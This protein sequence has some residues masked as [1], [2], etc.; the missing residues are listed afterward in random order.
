MSLCLL[1]ASVSLKD[2]EKGKGSWEWLA[3][4]RELPRQY[5]MSTW[6]G[7]SCFHFPPFCLAP[8]LREDTRLLGVSQ[9][10]CC[11][12]L[13]IKT[14]ASVFPNLSCFSSIFGSGMLRRARNGVTW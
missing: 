6:E 14:H 3:S 13:P 10:T 5:L 1:F 9:G 4:L 7:P 12:V 2:L 8:C 11:A